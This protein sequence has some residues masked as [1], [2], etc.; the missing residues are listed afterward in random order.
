MSLKTRLQRLGVNLLVMVASLAVF[1]GSVEGLARLGGYAPYPSQEAVFRNAYDERGKTEQ[2]LFQPSST[3]VWELVPGFSGHRTD[4]G[5]RNWVTLTV[6]LQGRRDTEVPLAKPPGTYRI[7][8]LGDSVAFG[9]RVLVEDD[10]VSLLEARLNA[11]STGL[12]YQ[13]LNFGVPGYSTWQ[14]HLMLKEKALAY[15]PDL[16]V[17]VFVMNDFYDN[18][19][20]GRAGYLDL[21]RIQGVAKWLRENSAFYRF[22]REQILSAEAQATLSDPCAGADENFCWD[23]TQQQLDQLAETTRQRQLPFVLVVVPFR[24]QTS[25]VKPDLTLE[26]RYQDVLAEYARTRNIPE[27]DLLQAFVDHNDVPLYVDD[28]HP[29]ETGHALIASELNAELDRLGLLPPP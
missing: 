13:I 26:P 21:T 29:N 18:N 5:D 20:A 19:V 24:T 14:E 8:V 17:L 9:A 15:N 3:R 23:T 6:N 4:W 7:A 27:I 11:R 10:F 25:A 12:H 22:M 2:A 1:F 28:Y 16:I